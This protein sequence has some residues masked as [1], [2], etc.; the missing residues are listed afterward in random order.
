MSE[1]TT[2]NPLPPSKEFYLERSLQNIT[3]EYIHKMREL[4]LIRRISDALVDPGN[5]KKAYR[6]IT[7]IILN[8]VDAEQC[9]LFVLDNLKDALVL[10]AIKSQEDVKGIYFDEKNGKKFRATAGLA[11]AVISTGE[12]IYLSDTQKEKKFANDEL[13]EKG[14]RSVL[15]VPLLSV[16][17][18]IGVLRLSAPEPVAFSREDQNLLQIVANQVAN[19]ISNVQLV[20]NLK[21]SYNDQAKVL[22]KLKTAERKL[23]D[24]SK[25]LELIV[26][27]RTNDLVQSEKLATVGQ[28]V[29]GIS[30]ELN[31]P[32]AIVMGYIDLLKSDCEN[33]KRDS[34]LEKVNDAGSRCARI[35]SDLQK[36]SQGSIIERQKIDLREIINNTLSVYQNQ[37]KVNNIKVRR[38]FLTD[39]PK[40]FADP[41]QIQQVFLNLLSNTF[42]AM[43]L[44]TENKLLEIKVKF[45]DGKIKIEFRDTGPGVPKENHNKLFEPF[46]TTKEVGRGT[47]LGLSVSYG[48]L[49]EHGGGTE[50]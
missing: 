21:Q 1:T 46:F 17:K 44:Q 18:T 13:L 47:G 6:K 3:E 41:Q 5:R 15:F 25:N 49:K 11:Y 19:V 8:E 22:K 24:Y 50:I 12:E 4:S 29:A 28:L 36:F 35:V 48:I 20:K 38:K 23:S 14:M 34:W 27:K 9:A 42:D 10:R 31:N 37:F 43:A 16:K 40:T 26:E 39:I 32:L 30:H 2:K 45:K 33:D 7:S